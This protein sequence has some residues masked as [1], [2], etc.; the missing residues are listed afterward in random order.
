MVV[1]LGL[2]IILTSFVTAILYAIDKRRARDHEPRIAE[3]TLLLWSLVGG[4]PGGWFAGKY[5]HHKTRKRSYRMKF[6]L[7]ALL[8]VAFLVAVVWL[9]GSIPGL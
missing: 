5:M 8:N 1:I 4:W 6:V 7:C 2:A 9:Q 3:Q